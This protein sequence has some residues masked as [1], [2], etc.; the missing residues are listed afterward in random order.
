MEKILIIDRDE[1][2]SNILRLNLG[3]EGYLVYFAEDCKGA[4]E[5]LNEEEIELILMDTSIPEKTDGLAFCKKIKT[6]EATKNIPIIILSSAKDDLL[7]IQYWNMGVSD[8]ISKPFNLINLLEA[9]KDVKKEKEAEAILPEKVTAVFIVGGGTLGTYMLKFLL[10]DPKIKILGLADKNLN[11]TGILL[12]KELSVPT[13]NNFANIFKEKKLDIIISTESNYISSLHLY[14]SEKQIEI[15]GEKTLLLVL[16][17]LND[18]NKIAKKETLLAKKLSATY[19]NLIK[20]FL[21]AID[22]RDSFTHHHTLAVART[23]REIAEAIKLSSEQADLIERAA[24]LHDIGKIGT[25]DSILKKC[26]PLTESEKRVVQKHPLTG[27]KIL[28]KIEEFYEIIPI[29]KHQYEKYD[30]TGSPD[31]LKG[32]NIP[33]GARI[34]NIADSFHALISKRAY[35]DALSLDLAQKTL[36]KLARSQFDPLLVEVFLE[37]LEKDSFKNELQ[38]ESLF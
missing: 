23:S 16:G 31:G 6:D 12:A 5:I 28:S 11:S 14:N 7:K 18:R 1:A 13:T 3:L 9:I 29:I 19:R 33:L 25:D 2:T 21:E 4:A 35:R 32:E 17:L 24:L 10:T 15:I 30:G 8:Y 38:R 36:A 26:G 27:A 37:I 22:A 34:I 20:A